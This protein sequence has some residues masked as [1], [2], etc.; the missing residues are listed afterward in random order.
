MTGLGALLLVL[1]ACAT[2]AA[3]QGS[4]GTAPSTS[5]AAARTPGAA[6]A[7]PSSSPAPIQHIRPAPLPDGTYRD[8]QGNRLVPPPVMV[9]GRLEPLPPALAKHLGLDPAKTS[10]LAEVIPGLPVDKAGLEPH[11]ILIA[12]EGL[13]DA[14]EETIR[15]H[16]RTAKPGD[17]IS[18]TY[19]RGSET[20]TTKVTLEPW[21][22]DHMVRPLT[23]QH[24]TPIPPPVHPAQVPATVADL[25]ALEQRIRALEQQVAALQAA[26]KAGH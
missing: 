2:V 9:G 18:V 19:R 10:V 15:A 8:L 16:L 6:G 21:H 5:P 4:A 14:N 24:F 13:P 12:V 23:P 7:T 3:Q 26:L 11:D 25:M 1:A 20:R 22:P 17:T